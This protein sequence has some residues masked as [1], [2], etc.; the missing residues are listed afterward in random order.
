ML[1]TTT[2]API[3]NPY[4]WELAFERPG[5]RIFRRFNLATNEVEYMEEWVNDAPLRAAAAQ[6]ELHAETSD[7]KPLAIVPDSELSRAIRE[8]WVHDEKRWNRW[9][10]D[11][12]NVNLRILD[13]TA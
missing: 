1:S 12:D 11:R 7:I 5:K 3:V 6:R 4:D 9:A 2:A 10:N 13:L 8:G